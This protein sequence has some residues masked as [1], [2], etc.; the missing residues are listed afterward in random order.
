L[1]TNITF[2]L[3]YLELW[4]IVQGLVVVPPVTTPMLVEEFTKRNNKVKMTICD[5]VR[6]HEI[7]HLTGKEY[8][9]D[10][11]DSLCKL[12]QSPNQNRK[13]LL[14]DKLKSI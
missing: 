6:D 13:M 1:K 4:D 7:P 9:F 12:Y 11:W 5:E 8:A 14:H 10:M 3:E 2:S